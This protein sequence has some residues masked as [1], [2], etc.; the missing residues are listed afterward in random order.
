[1]T[2]PRLL[3]WNIIYHEYYVELY[4]QI[5]NLILLRV[6]GDPHGAEMCFFTISR[7]YDIYIYLHILHV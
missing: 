2:D 6:T 3:Y 5:M 4:N 7:A 1:M